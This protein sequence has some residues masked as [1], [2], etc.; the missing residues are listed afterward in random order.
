MK[1]IQN[2]PQFNPAALINNMTSGR[3]TNTQSIWPS[4]GRRVR[5]MHA[6]TSAPIVGTGN[7]RSLFLH[8]FWKKE[9]PHFSHLKFMINARI[10]V[11]KKEMM[12]LFWGQCWTMLAIVHSK[13]SG[14]RL[15]VFSLFGTVQYKPKKKKKIYSNR[16]IIRN[17]ISNTELHIHLLRTVP[18]LKDDLNNKN[19][20]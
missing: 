11:V 20:K 14:I 18:L 9:R 13:W 15:I 19:M 3:E 5:V 10:V 2:F 7:K 1:A 12:S 8:R 16:F 17:Y 4:Q 6:D